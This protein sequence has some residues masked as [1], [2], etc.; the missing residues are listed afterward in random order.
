MDLFHSTIIIFFLTF[1]LLPFSSRSSS[2]SHYSTLVYKTCS[3]KTSSF[4]NNNNNQLLLSSSSTQSFSQPLTSLFNQLIAQSSQS[5]FFRT[6]ELV[7]DETAIVSGLFQCREDISVEDCF[8]CVNSVP[9]YISSNTLCTG[10]TSARVQLQGCHIQYNTENLSEKTNDDETDENSDNGN[11]IM[12]HKE[13]GEA[14]VDEEAYIK[15]RELMQKAFASLE[16]EIAKSDDK[17]IR[18]SYEWVELMAQCEADSD[19]CE[20]NACV[21]DAVR[22]AE[23]DCSASVSAQIYLDKCFISYLYHSGSYGDDGIPANSIPEMVNSLQAQNQFLL[24]AREG[25]RDQPAP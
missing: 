14:I 16:S 11:S 1:L 6:K 15:F 5:K 21:S 23:E 25:P 20:C 19:T 10:S 18:M 3:N 9:P 24:E 17:F 13:C 8:R 7:E 22:F 12:D 2:S 4:N